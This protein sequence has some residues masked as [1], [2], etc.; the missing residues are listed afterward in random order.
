LRII[1]CFFILSLSGVSSL[2]F[3]YLIPGSPE[4]IQRY[5]TDSALLE[6]FVDPFC[7]GR[8]SGRRRLTSSF[9]VL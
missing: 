8:K 2:S 7:T 6:L 4:V 1:C 3:F 9:R 5:K